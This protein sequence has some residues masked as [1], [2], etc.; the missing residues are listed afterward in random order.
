MAILFDVMEVRA[1]LVL[2]IAAA[3]VNSV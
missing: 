2:R 3:R 1:D